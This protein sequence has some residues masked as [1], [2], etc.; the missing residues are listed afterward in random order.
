MQDKVDQLIKTI[1]ATWSDNKQS[2][3][4]EVRDLIEKALHTGKRNSKGAAWRLSCPYPEL[5]FIRE[6]KKSA[7]KH[8]TILE[9][10]GE[11]FEGISWI[12]ASSLAQH[13]TD[14]LATDLKNELKYGIIIGTEDQGARLIDKSV[15]LGVAYLPSG[16]DYPLHALDATEVVQVLIGDASWGPTQSYRSR[17]IP[18]DFIHHAPATPHCVKVPQ[19]EPLLTLFAWSGN[20]D[21][22]FWFLDVASGNRFGNTIQNNKV[23]GPQELYDNM[24]ENYEEIVRGWG[25]NMPE[26][27]AKK[28]KEVSGDPAKM[29]LLDLG[30]GDGLV[31]EALVRLGFKDIIGMDISPKMLKVASSKNIYKSLH[32]VDL[33]KKLPSE[34][35]VFDI[36][37]CVG[38]TTYLRPTVFEEWLRVVKRNGLLV[39]THKTGV[40][41][42][43]EDD[44]ERREKRKEW[45][46]LE[47][48]PPLYYLPTLTDP[49]QERVHVYV[50]RKL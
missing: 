2:E 24:A 16:V 44:Q 1:L 18:G 50:Y 13:K 49:S 46:K 5:R 7:N 19:I 30:C 9:H 11:V 39:F 42:V 34:S 27:A 20:L 29:K 36:L 31:G 33:L 23:S 37:S 4:Q 17:K 35:G 38:T 43:W 48:S 10:I 28:I 47:R 6:T 25:Y 26:I 3:V 45:V 14:L 32:E 15:V 8:E 40:M 12:R 21:G 41:K 22:K